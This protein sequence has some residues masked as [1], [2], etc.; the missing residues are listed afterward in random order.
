MICFQ[1]LTKNIA[2]LGADV[3]FV[4]QLGQSPNFGERPVLVKAAVEALARLLV[5]S[6]AFTPF[7][8]A[9]CKPTPWLA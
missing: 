6:L 7:Y 4:P 5:Q 2:G 1:S 8:R 3:S 9:Q